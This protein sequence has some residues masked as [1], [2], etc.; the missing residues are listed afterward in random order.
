MSRVRLRKTYRRQ[1]LRD[2]RTQAGMWASLIIVNH[3]G[4]H[5]LSQV[6]LVHRDHEVETL[7]SHGSDQPF[8]VRIGLR[9]THW[10]S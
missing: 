10:R 6:P 1:W 3:P 9:R 7:A 5:S 2:S 4:P 8:A